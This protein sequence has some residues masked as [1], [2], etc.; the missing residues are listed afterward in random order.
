MLQAILVAVGKRQEASGQRI[1][2]DLP[3]YRETQRTNP[4][5]QYSDYKSS[6]RRQSG[7]QAVSQPIVEGIIHVGYMYRGYK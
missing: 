7:S 2:N 1:S 4:H 5:K 3:V 6:W